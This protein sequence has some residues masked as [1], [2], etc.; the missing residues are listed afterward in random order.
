M[1]GLFVTFGG[2]LGYALQVP[3]QPGRLTDILPWLATGFV[4]AWTGG[5]LAGNSLIAAP[6]GVR[7]AMVGQSA[8]AGV[9]TLAGA[10]SAVVVVLRLGSW[11]SPSPGTPAELVIAP[12][13][14]IIVWIGGFLMGHSM[15]RFVRRRHRVA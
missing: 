4:A 7:P 3:I 13:A 1:L 5:I 6:L 12:V 2:L 8:V 10:L 9:A 11:T 14:T 15:R